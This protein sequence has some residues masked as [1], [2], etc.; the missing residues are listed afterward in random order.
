MRA[1]VSSGQRHRLCRDL[2]VEAVRDEE[3]VDHVEVGRRSPVQ[4]RDDAVVDRRAPARGRSARSA[5]TSP[6]SGSGETSS[7][8]RS[9]FSAREAKRAS[10]GRG[11][12]HGSN[13]RAPYA[14]AASR[15]KAAVRCA[16]QLVEL[17]RPR[18]ELGGR[19]AAGPQGGV[20]LEQLVVGDAR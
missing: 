6:S 20:D 10:T 9:S 17:L 2:E 11:V 7:S 15:T 19:R 18:L 1:I 8:R 4:P 3:T 12:R 5:A 16:P 14:R 13:P